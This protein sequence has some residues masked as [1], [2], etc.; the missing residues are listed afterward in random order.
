MNSMRGSALLEPEW[1]IMHPTD[2]QSI[3]LLTDSTGQ[4][5]GGGPWLGAYGN[6]TSTGNGG[7]ITGTYD[8]LWGKP[9]VV[10][11]AIGGAG[12]A[13]IGTAANAQVW[14]RG[15]MRVEA[16]NSHASFFQTNQVMIRAERRAALAVYRSNG[17]V[18]CRLA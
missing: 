3:R 11:A 1:V 15:G 10:S 2:Y 14:N 9:V 13:L 8:S 7:Q 18:E 4:F 16:S 5:L 17:Y 6:T 12:T